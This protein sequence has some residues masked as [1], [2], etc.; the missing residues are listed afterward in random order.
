MKK[1]SCLF[2]CLFAGTVN[3]G[4]IGDTVHV[5][6]NWS[7]LGS[8]IYSPMDVLVE[9]G[10]GDLANV[11]P[12]YS[13]DIDD[14]SVFVDFS[15]TTS[16]NTGAFNG[17]VISDIDSLLSDFSVSTNFVGW[18]DSRFTHSSDS[19]MFNWN[20]LSFNNNTTF[21]L[22]F[23]GGNTPQVPEP[24]SILLLGLGLA[25]VGFSRRKKSA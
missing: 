15:S 12:H 5:A 1:I 22:D 14:T 20:G 6:H 4:L 11:S 24:A 25:G 2:V 8:E 7:S 16:W 19:L 3:A 9:N 18:D 23:N 21:Q 13:V 10:S 17:L